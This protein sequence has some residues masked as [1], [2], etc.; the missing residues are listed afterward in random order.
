M[1]IIPSVEKSNSDPEEILNPFLKG[2]INKLHIYDS[3]HSINGELESINIL[4]YISKTHLVAAD[5][6]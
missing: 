2:I 1:P 5:K 6:I 4:K 3:F